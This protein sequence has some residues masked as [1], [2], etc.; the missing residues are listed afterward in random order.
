MPYLLMES[1]IYVR[2]NTIW[3]FRANSHIFIVHNLFKIEWEIWTKS[4]SFL[5]ETQLTNDSLWV[6]DLVATVLACFVT[7]TRKTSVEYSV[8]YWKVSFFQPQANWNSLKVR[9]VQAVRLFAVISYF[10]L[11]KRFYK[12]KNEKKHQTIKLNLFRYTFIHRRNFVFIQIQ[13]KF[14]SIGN[15][16]WAVLI[17]KKCM[18]LFVCLKSDRFRY[19]FIVK[20]LNVWKK[21]L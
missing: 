9:D 8:F 18:I 15:V 12:K 19:H 14:L 5:T 20:C 1:L 6:F 11:F 7:S 17:L 13:M 10:S 2:R 4:R 16:K 21:K 3:N